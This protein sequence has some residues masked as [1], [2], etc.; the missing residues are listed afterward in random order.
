[1]RLF[2]LENESDSAKR[3]EGLK[4]KIMPAVGVLLQQGSKTRCGNYVELVCV[5]ASMSSAEIGTLW[6][7]RYCEVSKMRSEGLKHAIG[8]WKSEIRSENL[9]K[10]LEN[11][12]WT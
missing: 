12:D 3:R 6:D 8:E 2:W 9:R 7:V 5:C 10:P 11:D 1:M 4:N